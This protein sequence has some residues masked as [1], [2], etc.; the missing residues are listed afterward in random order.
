MI[1]ALTIERAKNDKLYRFYFPTDLREALEGTSHLDHKKAIVHGG[2][3]LLKR[4]RP[5]HPVKPPYVLGPT[6]Y[7]Q[8]VHA[9][10]SLRATPVLR[11]I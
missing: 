5:T 8:G 3:R 6:R 10:S 9:S 11:A 1:L 2:K 4:R 7:V